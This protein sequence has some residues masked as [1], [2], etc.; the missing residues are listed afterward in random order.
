[1]TKLT[2]FCHREER[3]DVATCGLLRCA[4]NDK[5]LGLLRCAR[6][7]EVRGLLRLA[8]NDEIEAMT[9]MW[10]LTTFLNL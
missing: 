2:L 6:N 3:S 4:R 8:R 7:I 5:A 9:F 10:V 1:M